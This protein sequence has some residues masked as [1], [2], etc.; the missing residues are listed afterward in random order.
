MDSNQILPYV[1]SFVNNYLLFIE[2]LTLPAFGL[3]RG[4]G[5]E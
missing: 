1:L 5:F 3:L 2:R 4:E